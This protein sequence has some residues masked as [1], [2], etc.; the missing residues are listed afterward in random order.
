[1]KYYF[2][3]VYNPT[4]DKNFL[5]LIFKGQGVKITLFYIVLIIGA[6][7]FISNESND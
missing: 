1:M 4:N 5:G 3:K 6:H 7:H 2:T